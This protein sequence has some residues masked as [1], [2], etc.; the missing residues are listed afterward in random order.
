MMQLDGSCHC[1]AIR[2]SASSEAPYPYRIC[3]CKRCQKLD[4]GL[5]GSVNIIAAA[6]TL[7]VE[8]AIPPSRYESGI[9]ITSFC[10]RCGTALFL[11]SPLWPE[12]VYPFA[13]AIDTPLPAPPH[14]VH[15]YASDRPQW[16]PITG[17][18]DDP[19]FDENTEE[20]IVEWHQR[21]GLLVS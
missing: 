4:G 1:G 20:S 12:W 8:A 16:A 13:S 21:L 14:F 6:A 2:F 18:A 7:E 15:I 17:T 19:M 11:D 3:H 9:T 5:G 10:P